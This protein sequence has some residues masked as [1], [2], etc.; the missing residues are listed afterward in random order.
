VSAR[1]ADQRRLTDPGL[2]GNQQRTRLTLRSPTHEADH[3]RHLTGTPHQ[4]PA[5]HPGPV[6]HPVESATR[7]T[8]APAD[9]AGPD[10]EDEGIKPSI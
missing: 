5:G 6:R 3:G 1:L 7:P 9:Y 2:T 4:R 8:P 10:P